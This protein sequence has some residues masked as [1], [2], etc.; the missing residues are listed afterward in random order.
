MA[1]YFI[2]LLALPEDLDRTARGIRQ[3]WSVRRL[4]LGLS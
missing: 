3:R 4:A 1:G 2:Y